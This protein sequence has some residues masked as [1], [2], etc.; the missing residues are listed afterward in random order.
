MSLCNLTLVLLPSRNRLY[1]SSG[2]SRIPLWLGVIITM[3]N[4]MMLWISRLPWGLFSLSLRTLRPSYCE[5]ARCSLLKGKILWRKVKMFLCTASS[6]H[7]RHLGEVISILQPQL[8]W[9][10]TENARVNPDHI[11]VIEMCHT[12]QPTPKHRI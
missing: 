1:L 5:E 4:K 12:A 11:I 8:K 7:V 10:M 3:Q 6:K 9:Y 2:V